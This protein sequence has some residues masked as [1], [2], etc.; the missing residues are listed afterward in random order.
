VNQSIED[1]LRS[2]KI[3]EMTEGNDGSGNGPKKILAELITLS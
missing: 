1:V 3:S 2:I